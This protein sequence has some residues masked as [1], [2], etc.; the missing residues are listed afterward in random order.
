[1]AGPHRL[2]EPI[3]APM[4][5]GLAAGV[6]IAFASLGLAIM[7][8]GRTL[9]PEEM[10][11]EVSTRPDGPKTAAV[12]EI[13]PPRPTIRSRAATPDGK[14][15]MRPGSEEFERV[16]PRA[17]LGELGLALPPKRPVSTDWEGSLL[18]RPVAPAAGLVEAMGHTIAIADID[19]VALDETCLFEGEEWACGVR[20]RAAF[21][22]FLR[23]RSVTCAVQPEAGSETV[24]ARC[25]RGKRDVG[26]W[27]VSNGWARATAGGPYGDAAEKAKRAR[28]GI[29]G[30]PPDRDELPPLSALP[31]PPTARIAPSE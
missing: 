10:P 1:M 13:D 12:P 6:L 22:A 17:P 24:T 3:A 14:A 7:A 29:F 28:K 5:A 15:D 20:A 19:P 18:H 23:G 30:R 21:R 8:G 11:T 25:R 26:P 27:L 9:I 2:G 16:A 4:R 31:K